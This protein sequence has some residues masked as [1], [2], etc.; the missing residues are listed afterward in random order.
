MA[1]AIRAAGCALGFSAVLALAAAGRVPGGQRALGLDLTVTSGPTGELG[2]APVG[3]FLRAAGLQAGESATGSIEVTN[4]TGARLSVAPV[5]EPSGRALTDVLRLELRAAGRVVA[6]GTL[7]ELLTQ[8]ATLR[9]EPGERTELRLT[10]S[11][12]LNA[13]DAPARR[14][15]G[16]NL[17]WHVEAAR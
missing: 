10:V 5:L 17:A 7:S 16:I 15:L 11:L 3:P 8:P 14:V 9:L 2:V 1:G 13:G 6:S 4:Q 12:P